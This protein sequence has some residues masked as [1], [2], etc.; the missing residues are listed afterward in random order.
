MEQTTAPIIE[1][2]VGKNI[3]PLFERDHKSAITQSD[4]DE[5]SGD[6]YLRYECKIREFDDS[7]VLW[8]QITVFAGG[9]WISK[10]MS[11]TT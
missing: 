11:R 3:C 5:N 8:H 4:E 9:Y 6:T 2:L 7:N 10:N 1:E